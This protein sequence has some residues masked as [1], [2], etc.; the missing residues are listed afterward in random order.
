ME[1]LKIGI[2]QTVR[3]NIVWPPNLP[4]FV[5]LCQGEQVDTDKLFDAMLRGHEPT[6]AAELYTRMNTALVYSIRHDLDA[7]RARKAFKEEYL[8]NLELEKKGEIEFI[9]VERIER[10]ANIFYTEEQKEMK[11]QEL[12]AM[13]IKPRGSLKGLK[14]AHKKEYL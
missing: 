6:H 12:I 10:K 3:Q 11:R 1:S 8:K 7:K 13:G 14:S 5:E 2:A 9:V 4:K